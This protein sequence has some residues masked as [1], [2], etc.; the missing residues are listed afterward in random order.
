M[1]DYG[2]LDLIR[3]NAE[4]NKDLIRSEFHVKPSDFTNAA[5]VSN[6]EE[7]IR[8]ADV[9]LAADGKL[10]YISN[11]TLKSFNFLIPLRHDMVTY[12]QST[13]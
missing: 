6:L 5:Q 7:I 13:C 4:H 12:S 1:D 10:F 3:A 2:I 9:I 11:L 8:S